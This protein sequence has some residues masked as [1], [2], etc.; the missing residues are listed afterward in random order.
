MVKL[1]WVKAH[2][3]ILGNEAADV[4]AKNAA[5]GV[6]LDDHKKCMSGGIWK[7]AKWRKKENVEEGGGIKRA[8]GWRRKAVTNYCRVRGGKGIGRW[9]EDKIGRVE[10]AVRG[11]SRHRII[12]CS[13]VGRLGE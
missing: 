13:G 9:W 6:P 11:K 1:G 4:L 2:M 3:G 7:W 10:G 8:M 5:E 12:L